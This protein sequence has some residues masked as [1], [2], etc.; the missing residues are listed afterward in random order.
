MREF[1]FAFLVLIGI[2]SG[3][4]GSFYFMPLD[5]AYDYVFRPSVLLS[6]VVLWLPAVIGIVVGGAVGAFAA[7]LIGRNSD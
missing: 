5:R 3:Y 6:A 2:A 7:L 4:I 1:I